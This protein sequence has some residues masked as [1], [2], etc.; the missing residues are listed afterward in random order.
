[1]LRE[2]EWGMGNGEGLERLNAEGL[3]RLNAEGL[4]RLKA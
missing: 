4:E 3:E 2:A 1:M